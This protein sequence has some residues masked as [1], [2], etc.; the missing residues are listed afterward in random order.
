MVVTFLYITQDSL[1]VG[2]DLSLFTQ[3]SVLVYSA[4]IW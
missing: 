3:D 1:L 2:S 4:A